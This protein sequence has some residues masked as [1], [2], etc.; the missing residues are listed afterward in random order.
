MNDIRFDTP[1]AP[2]C[3]DGQPQLAGITPAPTGAPA[4]AAPRPLAR[5]TDSAVRV[6]ALES[7]ALQA[8]CTTLD[9]RF[10][11]AVDQLCQIG[12]RIVVTGM[13]KSG[14]VARKI[15]AT[16]ASTGSPA[17]FVHPAEASH[18]DLGMIDRDDA[19]VA[20]SN[21]GE[22]GELSDIVA[23]TR[24]FA[25]PLI[26]ITRRARSSLGDQANIVLELPP[27]PEACPLGL[28][29]TTSTTMMMSLGDALAI[30]LLERRGF[31]EADF[32]NLHPGGQLG[33]SLLRVSD[34]M[35]AGTGIPLSFPDTPM[36]DVILEMTAKR[37]GCVGIVDTDGCLTGVITDGDLRRHLS[38]ALLSEPAETV[39]SPMPK[40]IRPNALAAEALGTMNHNSITSLFVLD[41]GRPLGVIHIHDILRAGVA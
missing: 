11:A 13:G 36:S 35:H 8:L 6:L 25:I 22:T 27:A 14:H 29:P 20:L 41:Q 5:P 17:L 19:V 12:G 38:P 23:Y 18:G 1:S 39:M 4:L 26:A 10:D 28:A 33:R 7:E 16:L 34:L 9:D 2:Q 21:S 40:T 24:R 31:T 15:A 3:S 32:R 37:L 30:A